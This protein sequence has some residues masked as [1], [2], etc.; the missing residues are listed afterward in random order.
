M[1]YIYMY[2]FKDDQLAYGAAYK[3]EAGPV[4]N[5]TNGHLMEAAL[6]TIVEAVTNP[7]W[8]AN[9]DRVFRLRWKLLTDAPLTDAQTLQSAMAR[10]PANWWQPVQ[11]Y[12]V[13]VTASTPSFDSI[14]DYLESF[15][16]LARDKPQLLMAAVSV[17]NDALSKAQTSA[18]LHKVKEMA[19]RTFM[20]LLRDENSQD[21]P[22]SVAIYPLLLIQF[23]ALVRLRAY[24]V[25]KS[26]LLFVDKTEA[27]RFPQLSLSS[28]K[29][30]AAILFYKGQFATAEC[31]Y[32]SALKNLERAWQIVSDYDVPRLQEHVLFYYLPVCTL[33]RGEFPSGKLWKMYPHLAR[34]Y[35]SIF[36]AV[37]RGQIA[38]FETELMKSEKTIARGRIYLAIAS[39]KRIC[40]AH[41]IARIYL[42]LGRIERLPIGKVNIGLSILSHKE[43]TDS[44]SLLAKLISENYIKGYI[45]FDQEIVV[46]SN[47][48]PFPGIIRSTQGKA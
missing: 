20:D 16:S 37:W 36:D 48:E 17:M 9:A 34:I 29:V 41:S 31:K 30:Q 46:L 33:C 19:S 35:K 26:L 32:A 1:L 22:L 27:S 39:L 10:L 21:N 18:D 44:S 38:E 6:E 12:L 43:K 24:T 7:R 40:F 45:V 47:R 42:A 11:K 15:L 8:P 14:M 3:L 5:L 4:R 2:L 28:P 25:A 23:R 13:A